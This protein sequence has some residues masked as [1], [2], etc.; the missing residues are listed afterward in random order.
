MLIFAIVTSLVTYPYW[1]REIRQQ[2]QILTGAVGHFIQKTVSYTSLTTACY[3]NLPLDDSKLTE[4]ADE[5]QVNYSRCRPAFIKQSDR[6]LNLPVVTSAFFRSLGNAIIDAAHPY[7]DAYHVTRPNDIIYIGQEFYEPFVKYMPSIN[8]SF[9]LISHWNDLNI[10]VAAYRTMVEHPHLIV[11]FSTNAVD[12]HKKLRIIPQGLWPE[13]LY[14]WQRN[15]T[16]TRDMAL[17][18]VPFKGKFSLKKCCD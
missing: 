4:N 8:A 3:S 13:G 15:A 18:M 1:S 11:W 16:A 6:E 5:Y 9:V 14:G 12:E 7:V 10:S 17:N 2:T